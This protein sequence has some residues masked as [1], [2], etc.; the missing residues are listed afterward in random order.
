MLSSLRLD[1]TYAVRSFLKTPSLTVTIIISIA[2]GIA[3]N[4]VVFSIVNEL[5]VRDLPVRDPS[6]LYVM[7]PA[8][9]PSSSIP[10]YLDFRDQTDSIFEGLAAHSLLPVAA[11]IAAA[12]E[13]SASGACLFRATTFR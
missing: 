13:R 12:A 3:A 9:R 7:E 10:V 5:L 8:G 1:V 4:T 6:Q 11:N 2:L